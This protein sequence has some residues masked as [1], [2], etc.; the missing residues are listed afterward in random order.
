MSSQEPSQT[1][2]AVYV[3]EAPLRLWHWIN[4]AAIV[5]LMVTGYLIG[6]PPWPL[7]I[8]QPGNHYLMGDVR[9]LHFTAAYVFAIGLLFRV[10]WAFAGNAYAREL[11]IVPIWKKTWWQGLWHEMRW[12]LFLDRKPRKY[13]GHNPLAQSAMFGLFVV[14]AI[15]Q[16]ITGFALYGEGTGYGSWQYI[17][18]TSWVMP[19]F[20][21]SQ[22]VHTWHH[23]GMWYL[24]IFVIVHVY[25]A[26]RED[27]MSQ[28]SM[29]STMVSGWRYFKGGQS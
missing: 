6:N 26:V 1:A 25:V 12:Y 15:F 5:V 9:F 20:G 22:N 2:S 23:L 17:L 4:A 13:I 19:L 10:Y 16:I 27:I 28:Q 18:F 14:G 21:N 29:V 8:G 24:V 3:Y 7:Q 11:F